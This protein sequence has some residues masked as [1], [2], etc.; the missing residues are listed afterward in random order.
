MEEA[1]STTIKTTF[2]YLT[3]KPKCTKWCLIFA[4]NPTDKPESVQELSFDLHPPLWQLPYPNNNIACI[5]VPYFDDEFQLSLFLNYLTQFLHEQHVRFS[6]YVVKQIDPVDFQRG[7]LMNIGFLEALKH[8]YYDCFIFH[9]MDIIPMNI[10][11]KY[12]CA[13]Y[14]KQMSIRTDDGRRRHFLYDSRFAGVLALRSAHFKM[15][16]GFSNSFKEWGDS[17]DDLYYRIRAKH[18]PVSRVP[19]N[20]GTYSV[21]SRFRP[22]AHFDGY[23]LLTERQF[24]LDGLN[25]VK[26]SAMAHQDSL[27]SDVT[28]LIVRILPAMDDSFNPNT[29]YSWENYYKT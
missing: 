14:P 11:N 2:S 18:I 16:N 21:L 6:I 22:Q 26:Y 5:V 27:V 24:S 10:R 23:P 12:E 13:K 8:Q 7:V 25:N 4:S 28:W 20:V 17:D 1:I 29:G 19:K 15:V 9:D 3:D